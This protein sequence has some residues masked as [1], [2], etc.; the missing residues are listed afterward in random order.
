MKS[1]NQ[2]L[3]PLGQTTKGQAQIPCKVAPR[4]SLSTYLPWRQIIPPCFPTYHFPKPN[5]IL[6]GEG[7]VRQT[8]CTRSVGR[9][10]T[11]GS[12]LQ[13]FAD[14][15]ILGKNWCC[16]EKSSAPASKTKLFITCVWVAKSSLPRDSLELHL[17]HAE[18]PFSCVKLCAGSRRICSRKEGQDL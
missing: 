3:F 4:N 13:A 1:G 7:R 14:E 11:P 6:E 18:W 16:M 5:F 17:L 10:M 15:L 2:S 12:C 9:Q 8:L